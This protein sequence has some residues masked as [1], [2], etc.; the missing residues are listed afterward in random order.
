[1]PKQKTHSGTKKRFKVTGSGKV[2]K[3]QAGMRHNLE[4][5]SSKR[6]RALNQDQVIAPQDAKTIK[7]LLGK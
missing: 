3:Q 1:M 6:K 5:K 4:V 2:M 7:K